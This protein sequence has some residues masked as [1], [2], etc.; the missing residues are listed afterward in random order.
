M[1]YR[2]TDGVQYVDV[3]RDDWHPRIYNPNKFIRI[4]APMFFATVEVRILYVNREGATLGA[5]TIHTTSFVN[6]TPFQAAVF[7][8]GRKG[9][10]ELFNAEV[11]LL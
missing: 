7:K 10:V 4:V 11:W 8:A 5:I 9:L 2:I 1:K 3:E 6:H